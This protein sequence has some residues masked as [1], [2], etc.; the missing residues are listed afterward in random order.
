MLEVCVCVV[1]IERTG[2]G[3][4]V[5]FYALQKPTASRYR[6]PH[7]PKLLRPI[8]ILLHSSLPHIGSL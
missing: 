1:E 7:P 8:S 6:V 3:L 5:A 2:G 4:L